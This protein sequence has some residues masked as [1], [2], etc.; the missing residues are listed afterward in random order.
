MNV[1]EPGKIAFA[2]H[3]FGAATVVQFIK[4]VFYTPES[5]SAP[6]SYRPLYSPLPKSS[7]CHQITPNNPIVLLDCWC[8][9]L[10]S[11][12][13]RWLWDRPLPSY[14]PSG[15]GGS[16][17]LAVESQAF[18]KWT[19]H[20][21]ATKRLLSA[22]PSLHNPSSDGKSE[23]HFYY[24]TSS[25][26]LSQSDFGILFPWVTKK[27]FAAEEPER[28]MRL[29]VRAVM[30]L[31]RERGIEVSKTRKE[32]L[33]LEVDEEETNDDVKIFGRDGGVRVGIG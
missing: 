23:P 31:L 1:H 28:I 27:V 24:P 29:N 30:Q 22:D 8:F 21:N 19:E 3:S 5:S 20:F 12:A 6:K 11:Q 26:H 32:D 17:I 13:T 9:P 18:F 10:R 33:E 7:I 16:A 4:S 2:G 14:A 25:A 15:P